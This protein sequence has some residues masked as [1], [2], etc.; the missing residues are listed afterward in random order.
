MTRK[1]IAVLM[2]ALFTVNYVLADAWAAIDEGKPPYELS[3]SSVVAPNCGLDVETFVVP[4]HMGEIKQF[5]LGDGRRTVVHIQDAHCNV[6]AQRKIAEIIDYLHKEYGISVLNLEGGSGDYDLNVFT[7][8]SGE[9]IREEVAEYFVE[10][11]EVNGAELYAIKNPGKVDLW[12]IEDKDLYLSNLKVYR[13]SLAYRAEVSKYLAELGSALDGLKKRIYTPELAKVDAAYGAYKSGQLGF[14]EYLESLIVEARQNHVD[15][16]GFANITILSGAINMEPEIDF[17]K[18][19]T[20]RDY[21]IKELEAGLSRNEVRELVSRTLDFKGAKISRKDFYGYLLKKARSLGLDTKKFAALSTYVDYITAYETVDRGKVMKE[22]DELESAIKEKLYRSSDERELNRLSRNLALLNNVFTISLTKTDYRF[23]ADN[24]DEFSVAKFLEFIKTQAPKYGL[25]PVLSDGIL[26]LDGYLREVSRFYTF[27]FE[28]D[29]VFIKNM[30]FGRAANGAESAVIVTGGFH[31]ENLCDLFESEKISYISILPRFTSEE[32]YNSPYF[33]I[34]AGETVSIESVLKSVIAQAAMMQIASHLS[35]LGEAVWGKEGVAAFKAAVYI[36]ARLCEGKKVE[37]VDADGNTLVSGGKPLVFGEKGEV[38]TVTVFRLLSELGQVKMPTVEKPVITEGQPEKTGASVAGKPER[39]KRGKGVIRYL[40]KPILMMAITLARKF[41]IPSVIRSAARQERHSLDKDEKMRVNEEVLERVTIFVEDRIMPL[42]ENGLLLSIGM[43]LGVAAYM[44]AWIVFVAIHGFQEKEL[45]F[46]TGIVRVV[47]LSIRDKVI[48]PSFVAGAA[49]FPLALGFFMPAS[50]A[51]WISFIVGTVAHAWFNSLATREEIIE[52]K[53]GAGVARKM[54]TVDLEEGLG[55]GQEEVLPE[56]SPVKEP[57]VK[58]TGMSRGSTSSL[59]MMREKDP[60]KFYLLKSLERSEGLIFDPSQSPFA[61]LYAETRDIFDRLCA[62]AGVQGAELYL[63]ENDHPNAFAIP[64]MGIVCISTG[65][66]K[67]ILRG[68]GKELTLSQIL[69][70][71]PGIVPQRGNLTKDAIAFI[72]AHE[73]RHLAQMKITGREGGGMNDRYAKEI[74]S[75]RWALELE[76]MAGYD[77]LRSA[78]LFELF[79]RMD[80]DRTPFNL[81][82]EIIDEHQADETRITNIQNAIS[83]SNW[84]NTGRATAFGRESVLALRDSSPI[85][86]LLEEINSVEDFHDVMD[87]AGRLEEVDPEYVPTVLYYGAIRVISKTPR[88]TANADGDVV[89][90]NVI[91]PEKSIDEYKDKFVRDLDICMALRKDNRFMSAKQ[92][93][94]RAYESFLSKVEARYGNF[95][96]EMLSGTVFNAALHISKIKDLYDEKVLFK[97]QVTGRGFGL[98]VFD[99]KIAF[100]IVHLGEREVQWGG[101]YDISTSAVNTLRKVGW[102][103]VA[104]ALEYAERKGLTLRETITVLGNIERMSTLYGTPPGNLIEDKFKNLTSIIINSGEINEREKRDLFLKYKFLCDD[105]KSRDVILPFMLDIYRGGDRAYEL[106]DFLTSNTKIGKTPVIDKMADIMIDGLKNGNTRLLDTFNISGSN[107]GSVYDRWKVMGRRSL[108]ERV[109]VLDLLM[110]Y[111]SKEGRSNLD[112]NWSDRMLEMEIRSLSDGEMNRLFEWKINPSG[113]LARRVDPMSIQKNIKQMMLLMAMGGVPAWSNLVAVGDEAYEKNAD[114]S[115]LLLAEFASSDYLKRNVHKRLGMPRGDYRGNRS[116]FGKPGLDD[117]VV[118]EQEISPG[119]LKT[120][121]DLVALIGVRSFLHQVGYGAEEATILGGIDPDLA[122]VMA[123]VRQKGI[124]ESKLRE[125]QGVFGV[126]MVRDDLIKEATDQELWLKKIYLPMFSYEGEKAKPEVTRTYEALLGKMF[127][128]PF[129]I[130]RDDF[131]DLPAE[132]VVGEALGF[133]GRSP[134]S[135]GQLLDAAV[136]YLPDGKIKNFILL[137]ILLKACA[138]KRPGMNVGYDLP[139]LGDIISSDPE[140]SRKAEIISAH[141]SPDTRLYTVNRVLFG[142]MM[143]RFHGKKQGGIGSKDGQLKFDLGGIFFGYGKSTRLEERISEAGRKTRQ[144][145]DDLRFLLRTGYDLFLL[146]YFPERFRVTPRH[147]KMLKA[148]MVA[149]VDDGTLGEE[150]IRKILY[151]YYIEELYGRIYRNES[152]AWAREL[153]VSYL[154]KV[155]G[156]RGIKKIDAFFFDLNHPGKIG[157]FDATIPDVVLNNEI[158]RIVASNSEPRKKFDRITAIFRDKQPVRDKHLERIVE[159]ELAKGLSGEEK[160]TLLTYAAKLFFNEHFSRKYLFRAF[161]EAR[162]LVGD[163]SIGDEIRLLIAFFPEKS[164]FRDDILS[165]ILERVTDIEQQERLNGLY[166]QERRGML[167]DKDLQE[168]VYFEEKTGLVIE[169]LSADNK[170][171]LALWIFGIKG[172]PLFMREYEEVLGLSFDRMKEL[173]LTDFRSKLYPKVGETP[174]RIF[175]ERLFLGANGILSDEKVFLSMIDSV[176]ETIMSK[177]KEGKVPKKLIKKIFRSIMENS[178]KTKRMD[179]VAG[180]SDNFAEVISGDKGA[181]SD[182]DIVPTLMESFGIIGIKVAQ[183][184]AFS[185]DIDIPSGLREAFRRLSSKADPLKKQVVFESL[186]RLG[187]KNSV[188]EVNDLLGSA[189]IKVVFSGVDS[190]DRKIAIKVKRPDVAH[191]LGRDLELFRKVCVDLRAHGVKVPEGFENRASEGITS[192]ADFLREIDNSRRL[193]LEIDKINSENDYKTSAGIPVEFDVPETLDASN[194]KIILTSLVEGEELDSALSGDSALLTEDEKRDIKKIVFDMLMT[195]LLKE[196]FYLSD[197]H[198]GNFMI[199]REGGKIKIY[200]IDSGAMEESRTDKKSFKLMLQDLA[201]LQRGLG[202]SDEFLWMALFFEK[203]GYLTEDMNGDEVLRS[204]LQKMGEDSRPYEDV[205]SLKASLGIL[206]VRKY[207]TNTLTFL[208]K[209]IAAYSGAT[210]ASI[211]RK[212]YA[213]YVYD[214]ILTEQEKSLKLKM[215]ETATSMLIKIHQSFTRIMILVYSPL[216]FIVAAY[217]EATKIGVTLSLPVAWIKVILDKILD[218]AWKILSGEAMKSGREISPEPASASFAGSWL[219]PLKHPVYSRKWAAG[220]ESFLSLGLVYAV[221]FSMGAMFT[222]VISSVLATAIFWLPHAGRGKQVLFSSPIVSFS[223]GTAAA[224]YL[225]T[226]T[227]FGFLALIVLAAVHFAMNRSVPDRAPPVIPE[228]PAPID[229]MNEIPAIVQF[230]ALKQ[231]LQNKEVAEEMAKWQNDAY[232]RNLKQEPPE[233]IK[234]EERG[235]PVEKEKIAKNLAGV[236]ALECGVGVICERDNKTLLEVLKAINEKSIS[237]KDMILLARFANATWKAGQVF[238]SPNRVERDTFR[239]AVTLTTV[240]LKKDFDQIYAASEQLY[241]RLTQMVSKGMSPGEKEQLIAGIDSLVASLK[242]KRELT[243]EEEEAL[244]ETALTV[245]YAHQAQRRKGGEP[246]FVHQLKVAENLITLFGVTDPW[247]IEIALL[248][249]TREDQKKFYDD[250]RSYARECLGRMENTDMRAFEEVRFDRMRLGVRMLSTLDS[251]KYVK[252]YP[253]KKER[254]LE[255]LKRLADPRKAYPPRPG[256]EPWYNDDFILKI[257]LIKLSDRVANMGDLAGTA[258]T[259][260]AASADW[261]TKQFNKTQNEFIQ[262]FVEKSEQL[263]NDPAA[264]ETFYSALKDVLKPCLGSDVKALR[265]NAEKLIAAIDASAEKVPVAPSMEDDIDPLAVSLGYTIIDTISK[266]IEQKKTMPD[267]NLNAL[268]RQLWP[269]GGSKVWRGRKTDLPKELIPA[270]LKKFAIS[271]VDNPV[272][273]YFAELST[274]NDVPFEFNLNLGSIES[275][276]AGTSPAKMLEKIKLSVFHEMEHMKH[277]GDELLEEED[278]DL[279]RLASV[280]YLSHPGEMRAHARQFAILYSDTFPGQPFDL[281]KLRSLAEEDPKIR[282]YFIRLADPEVVSKYMELAKGLNRDIGDLATLF[283]AMVR[284][285][286]FFVS[287]PIQR[288]SF[289]VAPDKVKTERTVTLPDGTIRVFALSPVVAKVWDALEEIHA[290]LKLEYKGREA[291]IDKAMS[292]VGFTGGFVR[293]MWFRENYISD[294]D[295]FLPS[296]KGL[297]SRIKVLIKEKTGFDMDDLGHGRAFDEGKF[298]MEDFTMNKAVIFYDGTMLDVDG[299]AVPALEKK[300]LVLT[301]GASGDN[302]KRVL[303]AIRFMMTTPGITPDAKTKE[304]LLGAYDWFYGQALEQGLKRGISGNMMFQGFNIVLGYTDFKGRLDAIRESYR[305][306]YERGEI[307]QGTYLGTETRYKELMRE[308][309]TDKFFDY[310]EKAENS[311]VPVAPAEPR[312]LAQQESRLDITVEPVDFNGIADEGRFSE[313]MGLLSSAKEML[314]SMP[315][316]E[317]LTAIRNVTGD[318]DLSW[319][320]LS[321]GVK[322]SY[323]AEGTHKHVFRVEFLDKDGKTIRVLLAAKKE[324]ELVSDKGQKRNI[325]SHEIQ[326]LKKLKGRGVP[327][328]G[329]VFEMNDGRL[330]LLEEFIVGDTVSSLKKQGKLTED[331]KKKV[332]ANLLGINSRLGGMTPKDIHGDNF[333]IRNGEVVMVDI[334]DRRLYL[335]GKSASKSDMILFISTIAAQLGGRVDPSGNYFIFDAIANDPQFKQGDGLK[336]LK[337]AYE[338]MERLGEEKLG[339]IFYTRGRT[340]YPDFGA[341]KGNVKPLVDFGDVLKR[342][343]GD[344]LAK[345]EVKRGPPSAPV[346]AALPKVSET[347]IPLEVKSAIDE[348]FK[349]WEGL[350][351]DDHCVAVSSHFAINFKNVAGE[352]VIARIIG[353]ESLLEK[354]NSAWQ[355]TRGKAYREHYLGYVEIGG[356]YIAV[357][358]TEQDKDKGTRMRVFVASSFDGLCGQLFGHYGGKKDDWKTDVPAVD[359]AD[360]QL[361]LAKASVKSGYRRAVDAAKIAIGDLR[362]SVA[363]WIITPSNDEAVSAKKS[364]DTASA[365]KFR[366]DFGSDTM[367]RDYDYNSKYS[368]AV[369]EANLQGVFGKVVEEMMKPENANKKPRALAY[370]PAEKFDLAVRVLNDIKARGSDELKKYA[371]RITIISQAAMP[372]NGVV[373]EIMHVVAGKGLLNAQRFRAEEFGKDSKLEGAARNNLIAFLRSLDPNL[374]KDDPNIIEKIL[375]GLQSIRITPVDYKEIQEWKAAQDEVLRSL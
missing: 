58:R 353:N 370:V 130:G 169:E 80:K 123:R 216:I 122:P 366:K 137:A 235:T 136:R 192:D 99:G 147:L 59:R 276:M 76:D 166:Y 337:V 3:G 93:T 149:G 231:L 241:S 161:D 263:K 359:A 160:V 251:E 8:I 175:M 60:Q 16:G 264:K 267:A 306:A 139:G 49:V 45:V 283:P 106:E 72:L 201:L 62:I 355:K 21:L 55:G 258:R 280:Q 111:S 350:P 134:R 334:G 96:K 194:E 41:I 198:G 232:Y 284:M 259:L 145:I 247:A 213:G 261:I 208:V 183:I 87:L 44:S 94:M 9:A 343:L 373:D 31:T 140:L 356:Q 4:A 326:G 249:D 56:I 178:D 352:K 81:L 11:G 19:N 317:L 309:Q 371:E 116:V 5:Y 351:L 15:I 354:P 252:L 282:S 79:E 285:T 290:Q 1:V 182:T 121:E 102:L 236:Y 300:E 32:G 360:E 172:K 323:H 288:P 324:K 277:L 14:R 327:R 335:T 38:E 260:G 349:T 52:Q 83:S 185:R 304:G 174:R 75:D 109:H 240:E 225:A 162:G 91:I 82:V 316:E 67:F 114:E 97:G 372:E 294:L 242:T 363:D 250:F 368:D 70:A 92:E 322:I 262:G 117:I 357:D 22:L 6:Y 47:P 23:Y 34:L 245:M 43:G 318:K 204:I 177:M 289:T 271:I 200:L 98:L 336:F 214:G 257:Q 266:A 346:G 243:A 181:Y 340:L 215:L 248:H 184:L 275:E 53:A 78:D 143:A 272:D 307:E 374:P 268:V 348:T 375:D 244:R 39:G 103:L 120:W 270:G 68:G 28:R 220:V 299:K 190:D 132:K 338:E 265:E 125:M 367:I 256:S 211:S 168:K 361:R 331:I 152:F 187:G 126:R 148:R 239:P 358:L 37:I 105:L 302:I 328:L 51:L 154:A 36:Q 30:K 33:E 298:E 73:I 2:A 347:Q 35:M 227:H 203:T 329:G 207:L 319:E 65:L 133:I 155:R 173:Y 89:F 151:N 312:R 305:Q 212:G 189:S 330:W 342:G 206:V 107:L 54:I 202:T 101:G 196:G 90:F 310:M 222:P 191:N 141:L 311:F 339:D 71:E 13:D 176:F 64:S 253:D 223:I 10:K 308:Y 278:D 292:E 20:E 63:L 24:A 332:V 321:G 163:L 218:V 153:L 229:D 238:Q 303:R 221:H 217:P 345:E 293:A 50:S 199:A 226:S 127:S 171:D 246:Y 66:F 301:E 297:A 230:E 165:S 314:E 325:G 279:K 124:I 291:D 88:D 364:V 188:R 295:M 113:V 7:S 25:K 17:R 157:N 74:D 18:A 186:S 156:K 77:V 273:K 296:D 197:P 362:G 209:K 57:L 46:Q 26:K 193:A 144:F 274:M 269:Y 180:I 287:H 320:Q 84:R 128:L 158:D 112:Y 115:L 159:A 29:K 118:L 333:I 110:Q 142:Y 42:V 138:E 104:E 341:G 228:S 224:M 313:Y 135:P 40:E 108:E 85:R 170:K 369:F 205:R 27:S 365:R 164:Y 286:S 344:Y 237:E 146:V 281:K 48:I 315:Q 254:D 131:M 219:D 12:G 61:P 167:L 210:S 255:Y 119:T 69:D 234:P 129:Y 100:N 233:F 95:A 150:V 179:I 195:Q 86:L